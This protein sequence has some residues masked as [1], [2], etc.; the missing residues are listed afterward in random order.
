MFL[1]RYDEVGLPWKKNHGVAVPD[2]RIGHLFPVY[3]TERFLEFFV[4]K[5][6]KGLFA[7]FSWNERAQMRL[8]RVLN[9]L[10][11]RRTKRHMSVSFGHAEAAYIRRHR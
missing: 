10:G 1:H 9:R 11:S 5:H 3:F 7:R 6:V 4:R 2:V 8:R